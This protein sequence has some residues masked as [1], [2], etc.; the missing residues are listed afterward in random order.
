MRNLIPIGVFAIVCLLAGLASAVTITVAADGSGDFKTLQEAVAAAP[1]Q[2]TERTIVHIKPGTYEG[3]T[4][5][6]QNK[7]KMTLLGDGVDKTILTY[8]L[9]TNEPIPV[10]IER[11]FRGIGV[12]VVADDFQAHGLTFQNASGDH[13]QA[14]ALRIDGDRAVVSGCHLIGWQD[15]LMVNKGRQY[16]YDDY[17][18]G[19]TDFIYG[20]GT[21]VFDRCEIHSRNG[22]YVTAASTP[23]DHPFGFVFLDCKLTGDAIAWDPATTNPATT[24]KTNVTPM[25][26]LGRPWRP[27]AAVAFVRCEMG[28]HSKPEGWD[29]WRNASN[30][31]TARYSEYHST[32]PG[33]N[34][35][36]R[37]AW[38]RQLT[39]DEAAKLTIPNI[40][41]GGDH[42][43]PQAVGAATVPAAESAD[44]P[45]VPQPVI[46]DHAFD[47]THFGAVGDGKTLNTG[48]ITAAIAACVKAGGG[49]VDVPSGTF[50]TGH[51]ELASS[52]NLH[53][54][55]GATILLS[56][57][58]HAYENGKG[59][60]ES[61]ITAGQ[62]H[63]LAITGDGTIDG[64]GQRWWDA[65]R[66]V[67][68][69]AEANLPANHRPYMVALD[70]CTRVLVKGVTLTNSPS[71][72]LVPK[73]CTGVTIDHVH[74]KAP[75]NAPNTD[76]L[77]PSGWHYV[78]TNCVFDVGDDCIAIKASGNPDG[79]VL[80]CEDFLIGDCT[81][82]RGH[83]LSIGGQTPGG[84]RHLV[85]RHCIFDGTDAGIRMKANRSSGG[86]VEDLSYDDL[87]MK[88][89]K[90]PIYITSYYPRAPDDPATDPAQPI[91]SKTPIW[92]NI[93]ISHLKSTGS[94][95]AG[96]I[97]GLEEMPVMDLTFSN[98]DINAKTGL[99]II[100]AKGIRFEHSSIVVS[101]GPAIISSSAEITGTVTPPGK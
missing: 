91:T 52:M 17:I 32:G 67:K 68:G 79:N 45:E 70:N 23:Q 53:L 66:K 7:P 59:S 80:S 92:Q 34:P 69:T 63:D 1:D 86:L 87:V 21:T 46:P 26:Y 13:G 50:L 74:F 71:F 60:N 100:H 73:S 29:N 9:N 37:F 38:T 77:D 24:Q 19:R 11:R 39:D 27:Y 43:N 94:P 15:T 48:A 36:K 33:A 62:C 22:G 18:A 3:Q 81:F 4:L 78:I 89:V 72:H 56:D 16:F 55:S 31:K 84:L 6:P 30:E 65:F 10:G 90:V 20:S 2:P 85:V 88:N 8:H 57:D 44:S 99:K 64:Q 51:I 83:G 76:G 95:E 40:L 98:V 101:Q 25:A 12:V 54:D 41:G 49:T 82:N 75:A 93:R 96:R 61:C 47:I 97:L 5:I 58:E 35:G 28:A 14:L 42:W